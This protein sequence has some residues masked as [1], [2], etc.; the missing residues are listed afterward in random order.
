[1]QVTVTRVLAISVNMVNL[2]L[3]IMLEVQS[4][5]RT[6]SLLSFE[7]SG[8]AVFDRRVMAPTATPI[9]PVPIIRTAVALDLDMP[10]DSHLTVEVEAH[11]VRVE[12]R[13]GKGQTVVQAMPVP[14]EYP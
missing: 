1:M 9:H 4:A 13:G 11:G 12:G 10:G 3:V 6:P 7:Q 2:Q 5:V 8:D 14:L